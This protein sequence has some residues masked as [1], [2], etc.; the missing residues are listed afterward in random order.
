MYPVVQSWVLHRSI[1]TARLPLSAAGNGLANRSAYSFSLVA[2]SSS[3]IERRIRKAGSEIYNNKSTNP[4]RWYSPRPLS[5]S[6][7]FPLSACNIAVSSSKINDHNVH[8]PSI[9]NVSPEMLW[10]HHIVCPSVCFTRDDSQLRT[11]DMMVSSGIRPAR[12]QHA[13]V[14]LGYRGLCIGIEQFRTVTNDTVVFLL[15]VQNN[16]QSSLHLQLT[17]FTWFTPGKNPGTSTRV[18]M[19]IL[20]ASQNRTNLA[21]FTDALMSRQPANWFCSFRKDA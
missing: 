17:S 13:V 7:Q 5:P 11:H 6:L 20:K 1:I 12:K 15:K 8:S 14:Y 3:P 4:C 19:G 9:V 18:T 21:A 2:I 10:R 16:D